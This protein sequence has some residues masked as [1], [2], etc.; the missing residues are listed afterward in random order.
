MITNRR[1]G[2]TCRR[3]T[4]RSHGRIG[5]GLCGLPRGRCR[6]TAGR[7]TMADAFR[8]GKGGKRKISHGLLGIMTR[9]KHSGSEALRR[10]GGALSIGGP[11][12]SGQFWVKLISKHVGRDTCSSSPS[13][14]TAQS[15][16]FP[17]AC[18][19]RLVGRGM[20]EGS[21]EPSECYRGFPL[22]CPVAHV[23]QSVVTKTCTGK[24]IGRISTGEGRRWMASTIHFLDPAMPHCGPNRLLRGV[25]WQ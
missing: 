14:A 9:S 10:M 12:Q 17:V 6:G 21:P 8:S 15:Q 13:R 2:L 24:S 3:G 19:S 7:V 25:Q 1:R 5:Q 16:H 20:A 11:S 4:G 22:R 23:T 18:P